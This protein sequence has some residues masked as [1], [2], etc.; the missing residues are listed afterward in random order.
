MRWQKQLRLAFGVVSVVVL[1]STDAS[2]QY[3]RW[4]YPR[5]YGGYGWGGWGADP[6]AGYMAGLG[7]YAK[8][9]GAYEESDA[10]AA[11]MNVD[12]MIRWNKAL[13]E[14][15][16][17]Y[18]SQRA[19]QDAQNRAALQAKATQAAIENGSALNTL[20]DRIWEF[21]PSGIKTDSA[22]APL[23]PSAIRDIPFES[24][25]EAITFCLN[26][27]TADDA[28]PSVL[29]DER[30]AADRRAIHDAVEKALQ[31]D[32]HGTV[33]SSTVK[34]INAAV[35]RL[36]A[37]FLK[38]TG[39]LD[40]V[41]VDADDFTKS[42]AGLSGM[43]QNPSLKQVL[44]DLE[45]YKGTSVGD[46]L[47]LMR[48]F[49]LRFAP[50]ESDRQRDIYAALVPMLEQVLV[51][52]SGRGLAEAKQYRPPQSDAKAKPLAPAARQ[53]F[54]DMSWQNLPT[55]PPPPPQP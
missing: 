2:A 13:R 19:Q 34:Q 14:Q 9:I 16:Q 42:L 33:S 15:Q 41:Y 44:A 37:K 20:L 47:A 12:T 36:R 6:G 10:K 3:R 55:P 28:W 21:N 43:L 18:Q 49:N 38:A 48:T 50:A 39:E 29:E 32:A 8:G 45:T 53:V 35:A 5:G 25:T 54:K 46:L 17:I 27:M 23:S 51:D 30:F 4:F 22:K 52:T 1:L 40:L 7:S 26:Q 31:E 24:A 11:S